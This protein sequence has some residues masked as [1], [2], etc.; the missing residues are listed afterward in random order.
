MRTVQVTD[1]GGPE[2]LQ[3][4]E[5]PDPR[6]GPGQVL[7]DVDV[8]E[9]LF[10]DT[11]LRAGW[12]REFFPMRPPWI[13]GTGVAGR[14]IAVGD[15]VDMALLGVPVVART[16]S[17]GAY[18]ERVAVPADEAFAIPD[19]LD[20]AVATSALHDAPLALDRLER[21]ALGSE[22]RVLVTASAGSLGQWFVPLA[23]AAGSFVV[24]AAGGAA[25]VAAVAALGAD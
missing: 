21:A 2:V 10:L 14:I 7:I 9:V 16:G 1:F 3:I 13:P 18:A 11:Q 23:T 19:D 6:P 17:E 22:S 4:R 12:G 24:G 25:K 5:V 8:V 15:G 20:P